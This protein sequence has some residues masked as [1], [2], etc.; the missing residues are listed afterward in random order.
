MTTI[1]QPIKVIGF[2]DLCAYEADPLHI[3][4]LSCYRRQDTIFY[5]NYK[6][7]PSFFSFI[8]FR[9]CGA[10]DEIAIIKCQLSLVPETHWINYDISN[11]RRSLGTEHTHDN[12]LRLAQPCN[13]VLLLTIHLKSLGMAHFVRC[14][15]LYF[16]QAMW[17]ISDTR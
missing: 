4:F 12:I 15:G 3:C 6:I 9:Q 14:A 2:I 1:L 17:S 8:Q 11:N 16:N 7:L 13:T 10:N 5:D